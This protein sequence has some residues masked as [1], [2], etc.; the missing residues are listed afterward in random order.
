MDTNAKAMELGDEEEECIEFESPNKTKV[1]GASIE[2]KKT[3]DGPS[4][5]E[6]Y[7]LN[8]L[9]ETDSA[10]ALL[11]EIFPG[12]SADELTELHK[13]RCRIASPPRLSRKH[14]DLAN[15][16]LRLPPDVAVRRQAR[17]GSDRYEILH[18]MEQRVILQH[19]E[20]GQLKVN[21]AY[22]TKVLPR[23]E[24]G[25]L[26]MTVVEDCGLVRVHWLEGLRI[27]DGPVVKRG[28]ALRN[29]VQC[30]DILIGI[31]GIAF[32]ESRVAGEQLVKHAVGR[33]RSAPDPVVVHLQRPRRPPTAAPS[34]TSQ[35]MNDNNDIASV[36]SNFQD[37][38]MDS[39]IAAVYSSAIHPEKHQITASNTAH[40]FATL[41]REKNIIH[42][43]QEMA[44]ESRMLSSF[45]DSIFSP[46]K[47]RSQA[48][49]VHIV[50]RFNDNGQVA[51]TL[52]VYDVGSGEE[53]Y[54][55]V[56]YFRD[57]RDLKSAVAGLNA[58]I[59]KI[60]FPKERRSIFLSPSKERL[61][62][63]DVK[64][65][66]LESYI[67]SLCH[68]S[69]DSNL[70][71]GPTLSVYI[72]SF[73]GCCSKTV[74]KHTSPCLPRMI[75]VRYANEEEDLQR[76]QSEL[77][78]KMGRAI[79]RYTYR[80]LMLNSIRRTVTTFVQRVKATAPTNEGFEVLEA[81][82]ATYLKKRAMQDMELIQNFLDSMQN[83][84][85]EGCSEA[86]KQIS[87][88]PLFG[89]IQDGFR[90]S[91][92]GKDDS[93]DR[94]I[95]DAVREQVEIDVYV[96]L[97]SMVSRWLVHG[98]RHDDME[99]YFKV[100]ELRK[101]SADFFRIPHGD[102]FDWSFAVSTLAEGVGQSTLPCVKL[103]AIAASAREI[104]RVFEAKSTVKSLGADDFLP[105]FI[106]CVVQAKLERPCALLVL[107]R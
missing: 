45:Q 96:P 73:L 50:N 59:A 102:G 103:K 90:L 47:P 83:L 60:P 38:S 92:P 105:I 53:W 20:R 46:V 8:E 30:G 26:G 98:W 11:S 55:P 56:R 37:I 24:K 76:H 58:T 70:P 93:I 64:C 41:L 27:G 74:D 85:L 12:S 19:A 51:Y 42:S 66:Q 72:Q 4:A 91:K 14:V 88:A 106:F 99:V 104:F 68:L 71:N 81:R 87:H 29:G 101:K 32:V 63:E 75:E 84:L 3:P 57:F 107:L 39:E 10:V 15:D 22:F 48:L 9:G 5:D 28:Q 77:R 97:R 95:R 80:V 1:S 86:F 62:D 33:L 7:H 94:L 49:S 13:N 69:L 52:W 23:D 17:D 21:G 54:A 6:S 82:G 2:E 100:E 40:P 25:G 65:L 78:T 35:D 89:A 31:D 61:A 79:Q 36:A 34:T 18:E 44:I 43:P 67:R 16:F